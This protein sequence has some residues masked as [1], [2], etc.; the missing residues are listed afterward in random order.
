MA[1]NIA[2]KDLNKLH[3][4][5]TSKTTVLLLHSNSCYWCKMFEGTWKQL[6]SFVKADVNIKSNVQLVQI[7]A[8]VLR[9]LQEK[10]PKLFE[11]ITTTSGSADLYFPKLM[12]F[13]KGSD[14][15]V[16][17]TVYEG[18]R[19][20]DD[21]EKFV[22]SKAPKK[23]VEAKRITSNNTVKNNQNLFSYVKSQLN[24]KRGASLSS[25]V[26]DHLRKRD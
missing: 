10:N 16:R 11:Y 7:E 20:K 25:I 15:K 21:L 13:V 3:D 6:G 22:R 2:V 1:N 26:R 4:I 19:T 18:E 9:V 5:I 17:K 8:D 14:G 23:K 12:V 24:E